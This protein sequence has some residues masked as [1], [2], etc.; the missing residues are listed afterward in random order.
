LFSLSQLVALG[1]LQ[2][3]IIAL[4][5]FGKAGVS[6]ILAIYIALIAIN[7]GVSFYI[8]TGL[9]KPTMHFISLWSSLNSY[10]LLGPVLL[11]FVLYMTN[12]KRQWHLK[13]SLHFLPFILIVGIS[14]HSYI[15]V[16]TNELLSLQAISNQLQQV[17][18]KSLTERFSL[19]Y[20]LPAAHFISYLF[21]ASALVLRFYYKQKRN[22]ALQQLS[23][24]INVLALSHL[25]ML[26]LFVVLIVSIINQISQTT[27]TFALANLSTVFFFFSLTFMLIRFGRPTLE[28][29]EQ[30]HL[31]NRKKETVNV[32]PITLNEGLVDEQTTLAHVARKPVIKELPEQVELDE[33]QQ[34]QLIELDALMVKEKYYLN[35]GLTQLELAE[36]LSLSRHQLSLL[37]S[38][39]QAGSFYELIN[40]YRV[41]AVVEA[42]KSRPLTD[43]LINI[44]YDCGFSSKSSFNQ[45]FKK[46]KAN[47]PSQY[48]KDIRHISS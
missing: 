25:M 15:N 43:N 34:Q 22:T 41:S 23:W 17:T 18:E 35:S 26:S 11:F 8:D 24:L 10:L 7:M 27:G 36:A 47:T 9:F 33:E 6:R 5:L 20:V 28:N 37:L 14:A 13:D 42:M 40:Q 21:I 1:C 45:V 29:S 31:I 2:G 44:A 32:Q 38:H 39:H 48:R 4:Y 19:I 46:Y 16:T 3:I 30:V 12:A